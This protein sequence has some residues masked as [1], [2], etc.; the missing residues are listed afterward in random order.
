MANL[1]SE[2]YLH[3]AGH[4]TISWHAEPNHETR[5]GW[6]IVIDR[7]SLA[8][9]ALYPDC[10][11]NDTLEKLRQHVRLFDPD[12]D[13]DHFDRLAVRYWQQFHADEADDARRKNDRSLKGTQ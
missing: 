10:F 1:T 2:N 5:K 7:F 3:Q 6:V 12:C 8:G 13:D 4:T 9:G 11:S